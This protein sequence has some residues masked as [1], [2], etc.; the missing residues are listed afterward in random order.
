[1]GGGGRL[2]WRLSHCLEVAAFRRLQPH[3]LYPS[4]NYLRPP[5]RSPGRMLLSSFYSTFTND[6][7]SQPPLSVDLMCIM[8]RKL[9]A[10]EER[11]V[12]L[13]NIVNQLDASPEEYSA[14]NKELKKLRRTID[15]LTE[16]R[17]KEKE[18]EGLKS[19]IDEAQDDKEMQQMASEEFEQAAT[20]EKRLR[21]SLLKSLLP[22][23]E[24]DE[25]DCILEV[26]AGTGGE[27]ASLFAMNIFKMYEKYSLKK[28]WK[29]EV[30]DVAVSDIK[31]YK[32]ATAAIT[33]A[34]VYGKL[35]F[36]SGIHRVQ[37]VPV[38]EKAGR[39]HTSAV[40]VAILPQADQVDAHLK[41]EDLKID[42]YRS[43]GSGGQHANTTNSAVRV[44]HV[45]TGLTIS[46]QDERSQHQNKAKALKLLCAKLYE[47][48]RSRVN[49]SRSKLRA[50]QIGSGDRS[51]RIRTYNFPQGRVT[52]HR[53][54]ITSHSI[55]GVM[56]G[57]DL[58][59]FVDALILK[60]EMD[61]IESFTSTQ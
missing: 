56:E 45:P 28:G 59:T 49:A 40:S 26:R 14:A 22:K 3:I 5:Y 58:D 25:R 43:G 30:L 33:G 10:L 36:E 51:E 24:A 12:H 50:Q 19:L 39:V 57:E 17:K 48:E 42:T 8:E 38:T 6:V 27:E 16:L 54:G 35:K 46:I 44:T 55:D 20:E 2:L 9:S 60:E 15:A 53:V 13:Q 32:E 41:S 37:R 61:A 1:M 7:Q 29:F 4:M 23:D 11:H 34:D 21:Y 31:G 47:M 18:I 52:D